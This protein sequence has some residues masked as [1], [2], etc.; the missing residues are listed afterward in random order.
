[1]AKKLISLDDAQPAGS[2]LP[3]A[4][5]T[6]LNATYAPVSVAEDVESA[7]A[8]VAGKRGPVLADQPARRLFDKVLLNVGTR[9]I[10]GVGLGASTWEGSQADPNR[11]MSV[12]LEKMLQASYNPPG[13]TGGYTT[14]VRNS[15]AWVKAGSTSGIDDRDM[16]KVQVLNTGATATHQSWQDCT[17]IDI[18]YPAGPDVGAWTIT[19]DGG[20]PVTITPTGAE[21]FVGVWRSPVLA[22]G[23]HTFV[24]TATGDNAQI[25]NAYIR[26]QDE[27][28]GVRLLNFGRAGGGTTQFLNSL[29]DSTW[30]RINAIVPDFA[31]VS[32]GHNN[33]GATTTEQLKADLG[34]ICD[35]L[36]TA[37]G[38]PIWIAVVVQ[39]STDSRWPPYAQATE[40]FAASRSDVCTVHSFREYFVDNTAAAPATGDFYTDNL[41]LNNQGHQ[42]AAHVLADSMRLPTQR[43]WPVTPATEALPSTS[44][45]APDITSDLLTQFTFDLGV[46]DGAS[47][48]SVTP[49]AGTR[50]HALADNTTVA[51]QPTFKANA[52]NGH[53]ALKF[54]R[55]N[56]QYLRYAP[57][58][59]IALNTMPATV[60]MVGRRGIA[61]AASGMFVQGGVDGSDSVTKA[62]TIEAEASTFAFRGGSPTGGNVSGGTA[63]TGWHVV[64]FV[65]DGA[66]SRLH[67]DGNVFTGTINNTDGRSALGRMT[68]GANIAATANYLEGEILEIREYDRA[69]TSEQVAYLRTQLQA[70]YGLT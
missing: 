63:D 67:I 60:V 6:D 31:V 9:P 33:I 55:A 70:R 41:H 57:S 13:I 36:Q 23:K 12:L 58:A 40:E 24:I 2:R 10:V 45:S 51:K 32:L 22:R 37:A 42:I 19:I 34:T 47:V 28:A 27:R 29:A 49:V 15:T 18:Y 50:G 35:R 3:A 14:K 43:T 54:T 48:A 46:A 16:K 52:A 64:V 69:L 68:V 61:D 65:A 44:P 25:S 11:Q 59:G 7:V 21:S 30:A 62:L 1:M 26:D 66:N 53:G 20:A 5:R 4:V 56:S 8:S 38:R 39:H 17:G